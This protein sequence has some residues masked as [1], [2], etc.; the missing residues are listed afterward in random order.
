MVT[1]A[2]SKT[3]VRAAFF[4][5]LV[6][7]SMLGLAQMFDTTVYHRDLSEF[8]T[9]GDVE[10]LNLDHKVEDTLMQ[11]THRLFSWR[12]PL[13]PAFINLGRIGSPTRSLEPG[14][15]VSN[16]FQLTSS[17]FPGWFNNP[18][19]IRYF[20]SKTPRTSL[21][22]AQGAGN[23]LYMAVEHS[24]NIAP[25][26]SF[27]IDYKRVKSH[28]L[29]FNNLALFN[30]ERMTNLFATS[31]Y[32]HYHKPDHSYEIFASFTN[33]KNTLKETYG[34][35][36]T[37]VFDLLAG[38]A[39]TYAGTAN[40]DNASGIFI[41]RDLRIQQFFRQRGRVIQV[42][43]TLSIPDTTTNGINKHWFHDLSYSRN[44]F[45]FTD[46]NPNTDIFPIRLISLLTLDSMFYSSLRNRVGHT[47]KRNNALFKY[48]LQHEVINVRQT[49]FHQS[50]LQSIQAGIQL[51]Q[52]LKSVSNQAELRYFPLGYYKG[53]GFVRLKSSLNFDK[54]IV[55]LGLL[56]SLH[57]TDYNDQFFGSNYYYWNKSLD[58]I[59]T[60]SV[61]PSL[62][63]AKTDLTIGGEYR[64]TNNYV[65]YDTSG[66]PQQFFGAIHYARAFVSNHF[67]MGKSF[68]YVHRLVFQQSSKAIM[69]VP[70]LTY[71]ATL[72][73]E[74]YLFNKNMWARMGFD[75]QYFSE[76]D[77]YGYNPV[78]RQFTLSKEKIGGYP[79]VDFFINARVQSMT[80]SVSFH[81]F[82]QG[83]FINDAFSASGYPIIG[84]AI[85]IGIKWRLF[86]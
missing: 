85:R 41:N 31:V 76:F 57:R 42:N 80:L 28:N 3:Y 68:H 62:K 27:G 84:R 74:G 14:I 59:R 53:D 81:N 52:R 55:S 25:N 67:K 75:L 29:Y 7:Q 83:Y 24:Q 34:I 69:P 33:N 12:N 70:D 71:K 17:L 39:R 5:I 54:S 40:F 46:N 47:S 58:Q 50:D 79:L 51:A 49:D 2:A 38:R 45:K 77:G 36:N 4:L 26:W 21:Q 73:K 30:Q 66:L 16:R 56:G 37:E 23:L 65:Y 61:T 22:Y 1:F 11:F 6:F 32:T 78:V 48:W 86:D 72:Y 15:A 64:V 10:D 44:V 8:I 20:R 13:E 18:D 60:I 19:S 9:I 82:T 35:S 43:D 63:V